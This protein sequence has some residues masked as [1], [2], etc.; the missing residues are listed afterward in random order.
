MLRSIDSIIT[1]HPVLNKVNNSL[2]YTP[3]LVSSAESDLKFDYETS[4]EDPHEEWLAVYFRFT[5]SIRV[6]Y[7]QSF[8]STE[9]AG[10]SLIVEKKKRK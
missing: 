3:F 6:A 5:S 9:V 7:T 8:S 1:E 4:K 2:D 10:R